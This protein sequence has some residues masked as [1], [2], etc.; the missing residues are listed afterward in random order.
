MSVWW[1]DEAMDGWIFEFCRHHQWRCYTWL[2][3]I[4][5]LGLAC[6]SEG[7]GRE[8][9]GMIIIIIIVVLDERRLAR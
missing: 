2:W 5:L 6:D 1:R 4:F 8:G 3:D 9:V 7:G